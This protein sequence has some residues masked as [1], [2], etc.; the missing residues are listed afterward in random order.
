MVSGP[1]AVC[2]L[3]LALVL[4]KILSGVVTDLFPTKVGKYGPSKCTLTRI[5]CHPLQIPIKGRRCLKRTDWE[6]FREET[7]ILQPRSLQGKTVQDIDMMVEEVT[8]AVTGAL[9]KHT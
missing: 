5:S 3:K 6:K 1:G 2:M 8:R 4:R 9:D 7:G